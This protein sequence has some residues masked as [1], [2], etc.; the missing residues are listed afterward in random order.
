MSY[1][2][3]IAV[4]A[5]VS[6]ASVGVDVEYDHNDEVW[7]EVGKLIVSDVD[8]RPD[9]M[10][11]S[12]TAKEAAAKETGL[13]LDLPLGAVV[14][15]SV[16]HNAA[17]AKI[18]HAKTQRSLWITWFEIEGGYVGAVASDSDLPV[19]VVEERGNPTTRWFE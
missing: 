13:G 4:V 8:E 18:S 10:V 5:V 7:S 6:G 14:L 12:W 1:S 15:E 17:R 9:K 16:R 19:Q 2:Q 3:E 11:K